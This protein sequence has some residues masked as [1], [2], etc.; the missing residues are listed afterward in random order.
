LNYRDEAIN[1]VSTYKGLD[2]VTDVGSFFTLYTIFNLNVILG[3][4][5]DTQKSSSV[6]MK[7]T[8][9]ETASLVA[10]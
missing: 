1:E 2:F 10:P 9:S 3:R 8:L 4:L 5:Y 7:T 6:G